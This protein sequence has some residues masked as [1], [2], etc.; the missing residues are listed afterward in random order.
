MYIRSSVEPTENIYDEDVDVCAGGSTLVMDG[1]D[2][3]FLCSGVIVQYAVAAAKRIREET[4][5][6]VRVIDMYSIKPIDKNAIYE[7]T[8]TGNVIVATG[9]QYL[10]RAW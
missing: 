4:R 5:K 6:K 1:D 8:K 9:S 3:A 10:W 7:A 2:G